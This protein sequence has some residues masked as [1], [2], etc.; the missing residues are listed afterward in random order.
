M[1]DKKLNLFA[2]T[3]GDLDA[4]VIKTTGVGLREGE[5]AA[6]DDIAASLE[7]NRNALMRF[8]IRWFLLEYRA[9]RVDLGAYIEQPPPPKKTLRLP[10]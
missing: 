10:E 9:G 5:I 1:A 3:E 7:I 2:K 8:A 4:G 6:I